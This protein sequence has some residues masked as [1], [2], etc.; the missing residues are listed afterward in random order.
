[1]GGDEFTVILSNLSDHKHVE[2]CAQRIIRE[3]ERSFH[4]GNEVIYVSASIGITLYPSDAADIDALIKNADQAMYAAKGKG[5]N[6]YSYFTQSLQ[7]AAQNRMKLIYDMRRALAENQFKVYFQ[8]IV[9]VSS[10]RIRKAEALLRWHHPVRGVIGPLEFIPIAEE[11]GLINEIGNWIFKESARWAKR[12]MNLESEGF[13]VSVNISPIQFM[14]ANNIQLT[15]SA[16]LR[17]LGLPGNSIVIEIT[18]GL[19]LNAENSV[20]EKILAFRDAGIQ[21]AIDDFGTGYSS[22]AYLKKFNIDYLKIDRSFVKNLVTDENDMALSDAII[23]LAHKLGLRVIAEGVESEQQHNILAAA[24]C[25]YVQGYL[26]SQPIPGEEFEILLKQG[27]DIRCGNAIS[28][29]S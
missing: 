1:L 10:G 29:N 19:L 27:W 8:A 18:E 5:R 14:A 13:Q 16:Y 4:I 11:I 2:D 26:F 12:W 3:L 24:G 25:D 28:A 9:E 17:E 20:I 23:G 22:L 15:W 21:V 6:Q 7:Q